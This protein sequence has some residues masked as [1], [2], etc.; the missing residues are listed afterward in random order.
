MP[1]R[2]GFTLIELLITITI[3]AILSAI[4]MTVY[5]QALVSAR[6][7]RRKLDLQ[8]IAQALEVYY[9]KNSYYPNDTNTSGPAVFSDQTQPWI[10]GLGTS[11]MSS[12]PQ[13]PKSNWIK[14]GVRNTHWDD[15]LVL[16]YSYWTPNAAQGGIYANCPVAGQYYILIAK[17]ENRNDPDANINKDYKA[18]YGDLGYANTIYAITSK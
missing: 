13:D 6:D 5:Q 15:D 14:N 18:C 17:L 12:I 3:I 16:G 11:Y 9:Q 2:R 10:P 7:G 4:G 8:N 1:K